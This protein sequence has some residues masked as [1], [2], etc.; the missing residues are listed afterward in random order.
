M[1]TYI[2]YTYVIHILHIYSCGNVSH[3]DTRVIGLGDSGNGLLYGVPAVNTGTTTYY[4]NCIRKYR[5]AFRYTYFYTILFHLQSYTALLLL[6]DNT[7][8]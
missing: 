8:V 4:K 6:M 1:Y 3:C 2:Y 7:I 5:L